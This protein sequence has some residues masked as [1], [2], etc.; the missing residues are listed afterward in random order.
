MDASTQPRLE[1]EITLRDLFEVLW[2]DKWLILWMTLAITLVVGVAAWLIPKSYRAQVVLSPVSDVAGAGGLGGT[3]GSLA[4]QFGGLASLAG[5][6]ISGDSKRAESVAVLQ[7]EALTTK[8]IRD[9]DLLPVLYQKKWNAATKSWNENNTR[10]IPTLWKA[11][12]YFKKK[13]RSI[14]TDAK[15]G[16]VTLSITWKDPQTAAKWANDLVEMTNDYLR[17][18]AI[19]ESERNIAY[20]NDQAAKTNV[21]EAKQAIYKILQNEINKVMLARGSMEYAFRILD[22]AVAPD[23]PHSPQKLIWLLA[24]MFGG[25]C[26]SV[27]VV[28]LRRS[29]PQREADR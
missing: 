4:S 14:S 11:N 10:K 27:F 13:V 1:D 19:E 12:L 24:G 28:L 29:P 17:S 26:I 3:L 2:R 20:L 8:Y 21:V 5:I 23:N 18:K 25:F 15:T 9:N 22:P 16:L 7:S 6:S